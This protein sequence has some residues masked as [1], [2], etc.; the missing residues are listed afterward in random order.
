M[1]KGASY[2]H[3]NINKTA[4]VPEFTFA[5]MFPVGTETETLVGLTRTT[6]MLDPMKFCPLG[7]RVWQISKSLQ[8]TQISSPPVVRNAASFYQGNNY[9]RMKLC[10]YELIGFC[11]YI[12]I[13]LNVI[14]VYWED[15]D[16][17]SLYVGKE[18]R[19]LLYVHVW[20][21]FSDEFVKNISSTFNYIIDFCIVLFIKL[22]ASI[23]YC[24]AYY[25]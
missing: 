3:I 13:H 6:E 5:I 9:E 11:P 21:R 8:Y 16:S 19:N 4:T 1:W 24:I 10:I 20:Q 25:I 15:A 18:T 22:V 17:G 14:H 7:R 2:V 23:C 12:C